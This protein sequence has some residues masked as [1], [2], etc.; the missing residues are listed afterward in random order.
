[1]LPGLKSRFIAAQLAYSAVAMD[2]G[3]S[4]EPLHPVIAELARQY[5]D[6]TNVLG[7]DRK[8][9]M[10]PSLGHDFVIPSASQ[11]I[12]PRGKTPSLVPGTERWFLG[13]L[14]NRKGTHLSG[15]EPGGSDSD[16]D[17]V[18]KLL[19]SMGNALQSQGW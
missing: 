4:G 5:R 8:P 15:A 3:V 10:L 6:G 11:A 1:M 9:F 12:G 16:E 13:N 14:V 19:D 18:M 2:E 7:P 17:L